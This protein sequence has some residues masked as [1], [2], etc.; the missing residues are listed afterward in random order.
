MTIWQVAA[1]DGSR[2]YADI[3]LQFGVILVG[4]GS[5]GNYFDNKETYLN[6]QHWTYRP[7]IPTIAEQMKQGDLVI[8]KKPHGNEWEIIAVG[9]VIS[10]YIHTETFGDVD[11]WDLQHCRKIKWKIPHK[12]TIISGLRRGTLFAVNRQDP[13]V[14]AQNIWNDGREQISEDIPDPTKEITVDELIDSIMEYG[15]PVTSSELIAST[16]WKLKRIAKWYS[17]HGADVGEHEIRTFLIVPLFTSVGW[18]E[19]KI[20][21]EWNNIDVSI[22]DSPYSK[23]SKPILLIESKRLGDGLLYAPSQAQQYAKQFPECR[24]FIVSDGIRYKLYERENN[25]WK[26]S[27]YMNLMSPKKKHPYYKDVKGAVDFF[28]KIMSSRT[29]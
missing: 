29:I 21:I 2:D 7:F 12:K 9:E 8:L 23:K 10:D 6:Q 15:L 1:G 5:E 18:A 28:L 26:Y 4:P 14:E 19:Q 17:W 25:D 11:G 13:I 27:A 16:I 24:I 22:F 3:F 20:K